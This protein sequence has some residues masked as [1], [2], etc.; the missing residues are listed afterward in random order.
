V[1]LADG[2]E[3]EGVRYDQ[4]EFGK[5]IRGYDYAEADK[6][7][8]DGAR[9]AFFLVGRQVLRLSQSDGEVVLDGPL[10]LALLEQFYARD[11]YAMRSASELWRQSFRR[12][13][14]AVQTGAGSDR[15]RADE[16]DG[17]K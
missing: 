6:L 16:G 8:L 2:V 14:K 7:Q 13:G 10:D 17:A 4:I 12:P 9:K 3:I 1:R 15:V 5:R 11:L